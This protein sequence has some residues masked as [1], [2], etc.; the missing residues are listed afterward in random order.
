M[1]DEL[2]YSFAMDERTIKH[3]SLTVNGTSDRTFSLNAASVEK[4]LDDSTL[5]F[6]KK[7]S[8]R[9][10]ERRPTDDDHCY[11]ANSNLSTILSGNASPRT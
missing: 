10:H 5:D 2:R 6:Q 8:L 7:I 4:T 1:R 9:G 3:E 11:L